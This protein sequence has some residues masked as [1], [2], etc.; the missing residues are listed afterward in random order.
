MKKYFRHSCSAAL[1]VAL[2]F[3]LLQPS[4]GAYAGGSFLCPAADPVSPQFSKGWRVERNFRFTFGYF[5]PAGHAPKGDVEMPPAVNMATAELPDARKNI[6]EV[7]KTGVDVPRMHS[8]EKFA[9]FVKA[10]AFPESFSPRR[11]VMPIIEGFAFDRLASAGDIIHHLM[12]QNNLAVYHSLI[13]PAETEYSAGNPFPPLIVGKKA[14]KEFNDAVIYSGLG[15]K[16][17]DTSDG[18]TD[19][20]GIRARCEGVIRAFHG[21][22]LKIY[23]RDFIN[24]SNPAD[25]RYYVFGVKSGGEKGFEKTLRIIKLPTGPEVFDPRGDASKPYVQYMIH[26]IKEEYDTRTGFILGVP[27]VGSAA[28]DSA[29]TKKSTHVIEVYSLAILKK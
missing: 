24:L 1:V 26:I 3:S 23:R 5:P 28:F 14:Q 12:D 4:G 8:P 22:I 25:K 18:L 7:V 21:E 27:P 15:L 16:S 2:T 19:E 11:S 13:A 20:A 29:F 10:Y 17:E 6:K 9:F